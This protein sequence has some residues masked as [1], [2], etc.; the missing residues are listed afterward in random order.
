MK[1]LLSMF[2]F[3]IVAMTTTASAQEPLFIIDGAISSLEMV[4]QSAQDII[5]IEVVNDSETLRSYEQGM[6]MIPNSLTSVVVITTKAYEGQDDEWLAV[7]EMP[8][9]MGG[10]LSTF[11]DWVMQNIRYPEEAT[12]KGIEGDVVV[13]FCV[14]KDGY[15]KES[16]I[17]VLSTPDK[18][19]SDEVIRVLKSSPQWTPGKQKGQPVVVQF[20]LP[21]GFKV[22]KNVEVVTFQ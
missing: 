10:N 16:R 14:G 22:V 17:T 3:A 20:T 6:K 7:E 5:S 15:I 11:R 1:R 8:M 4:K 18:L 2:A 21:V 9:F 13:N 19:L 12:K